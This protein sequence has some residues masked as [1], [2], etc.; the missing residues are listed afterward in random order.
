MTRQPESDTGTEVTIP[1][2]EVHSIQS[3]IN[4]QT[5]QLLIAQPDSPAPCGG[6]YPVL[7]V[8]DANACFGLVTDTIRMLQMSLDVPPMIIVGIGYP[9]RRH[10]ETMFLRLRD[11]MPTVDWRYELV[12]EPWKAFAEVAVP[13]GAEHFLEFIG[14]ELKPYIETRFPADPDDS[15]IIGGSAGGLFGLFA[16]FHSERPFQRYVVGSPPFSWDDRVIFNYE[17]Q[18]AAGHDDLQA[19]VF[20]G[21]GALETEAEFNAQLEQF[22]EPMRKVWQKHGHTQIVEMM[23]PMLSQLRSRNYPG[24]SLSSDVFDAEHHTSV[25]PALYS[26][27]LR[28]VYGTTGN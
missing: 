5:Y 8:L 22:P 14:Q 24:L 16:L 23:E 15:G 25:V 1:G 19:R 20:I 26:R 18:Y 10:M 13:G 11:Y 12:S 28:A 2:T 27:G 21:A 6:H 4:G 7:Y 3:S 17:Q 9:V